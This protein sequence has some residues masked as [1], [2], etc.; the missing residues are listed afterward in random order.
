MSL[1][2]SLRWAILDGLLLYR[3]GR[4]QARAQ[5]LVAELSPDGPRT[6]RRGQRD[7]GRR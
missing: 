4:L 5:T 3:M 1:S 6:R 7:R 2:P